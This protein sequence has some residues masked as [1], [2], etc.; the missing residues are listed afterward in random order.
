M[1]EGSLMLAI[2]RN[3]FYT[4][5]IAVM[6]WMCKPAEFLT[7]AQLGALARAYDESGIPAAAFYGF[8]N[9]MVA[10]THYKA[11]L[12]VI[13]ANPQWVVPDDV[14]AAIDGETWKMRV[15]AGIYGAFVFG[16]DCHCCLG[17]RLLLLT[18]AAFALGALV[19]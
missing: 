15:G 3:A 8:R 10:E 16:T 17:W 19:T 2:V 1:F 5:L 7:A 18:V 4:A 14:R 12:T 9:E 13:A 11:L 6:T